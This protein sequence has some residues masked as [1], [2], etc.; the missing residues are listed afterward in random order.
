MKTSIQIS[1]IKTV[2]LYIM[3]SFPQ[4][5][6][7]TKLF[8]IL[9][10][11]QQDYLVKYGKVLIED[12]FMAL[13]YGPV[14]T[15]IYKAL[16]T[17]G[18]KP[19]EEGFNDFLTGIEV[20]E[21]KIYASAKPDMD[22]ISGSDKRCLDAAITKYRDTDPYDQSDLSNDSAWKEFMTRIKDDPQKNLLTIM[23]IARA[24]KA[25]KEMVDYIRKKQIVRNALS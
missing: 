12:S 25:N 13:K 4:G 19:T 10:F 2:L 18:R 23:D 7:Y 17:A 20:H 9:Y 6:E 24:G 5:V 1:K 21:K 3:Q 8:E 14:P 15:Y 11:A 22:Y 16:Q